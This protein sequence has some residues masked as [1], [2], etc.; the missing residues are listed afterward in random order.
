MVT[1]SATVVNVP[2]ANTPKALANVSPGFERG[3]NPGLA[4]PTGL[5]PGLSLTLEPRAQISRRLR[6]FIESP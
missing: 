5:N 3:E 4:F 6:R 1:R 2:S